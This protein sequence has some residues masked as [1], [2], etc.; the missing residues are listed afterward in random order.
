MPV[1]IVKVKPLS[2]PVARD[3]D[4]LKNNL[5][6]KMRMSRSEMDKKKALSDKKYNERYGAG[7]KFSGALVKPANTGS[8]NDESKQGAPEEAIKSFPPASVYTELK[9]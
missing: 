6:E 1:S 8:E 3:V 7:K 2:S 5:S 4:P 9:P